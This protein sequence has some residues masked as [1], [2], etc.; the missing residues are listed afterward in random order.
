MSILRKAWPRHLSLQLILLFILFTAG[1]TAL[2]TYLSIEK[3]VEHITQ[4]IKRQAPALANN[5][6]A[7]GANFL[8]VRDYTAIEQML[9]RAIR[10]PG[11]LTIQITDATGKR[12]GDCLLYTSDAADE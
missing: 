9:E 10:F 11:V 2:F 4:S 8:L 7:T 1:A 12:V 6:S 3:Q 5:L